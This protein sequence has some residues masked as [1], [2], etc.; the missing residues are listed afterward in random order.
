[1]PDRPTRLLAVVAVALAAAVLPSA[2]AHAQVDPP[3]SGALFAFPGAF[4]TPASP[5]SAGH[6]LADRWLGDAPWDQPAAGIARWDVQGSLLFLREDRQDLHA[7]NR[8]FDGGPGTLD[9]GGA[10]IGGPLPWRTTGWL[11]AYRPEARSEDVAFILGTGTDP[12]QPSAVVTAK[13]ETRETRVGGALSRGFGSLR[14][15][16]ALEWTDRSDD[17]TRTLESGDPASG[18]R[19]TDWSGTAVGAQAGFRWAYGD[20]GAGQWVI[21]GAVRRMPEL[22]LSGA[23]TTDLLVGA[24]DSSVTT[25]RASGWEG[26]LSASYRLSSSVRFILGGGTRTAMDWD[27]LGLTSGKWNGGS[28]AFDY[29]DPATP[30]TLRA[31]YGLDM[32]TD[33]PE[34][35]A[36][37]LGLGFGWDFGGTVVEIGGIH[38]G[39][40]RPGAPT[41]Y[42]DRVLVGFH[43]AL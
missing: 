3:S 22:E 14:L 19:H 20:S 32:Q 31:G 27:G 9:F 23:N 7:A 39:I 29:H 38:R 41:S 17:W 26:G 35:H 13:T 12:S 16:L 10:A 42:Q 36:G 21:G 5:A 34:E 30:W 15:G 4:P 24:S 28:L 43:V 40:H 37:T 33:S 6:A 8:E 18:T 2:T 1:M 11:Y 25:R